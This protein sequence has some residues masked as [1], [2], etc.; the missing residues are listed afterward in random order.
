MHVFSDVRYVEV[1]ANG[2]V[3]PPGEMGEIVNTNLIQFAFPFIRYK[4]GDL[5]IMD[6]EPCPCGR[7]LPVLKEILG[8]TNDYLVTPEGQYIHSEFF[9]YTFRVKPEV[10]KFQV[11]QPNRTTLHIR[12]VTNQPVDTTWL[13]TT[14]AEVQAR[15]GPQMKIDV[16]LVDDIGLTEAG[17]YRYII[18]EVKPDFVA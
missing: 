1:V 4:N 16:Q 12:L 3:V 2:K 8:R 17:K 9:A 10:D 18:S 5:G 15:F 7:S 11:Y 14:H 13:N 6:S